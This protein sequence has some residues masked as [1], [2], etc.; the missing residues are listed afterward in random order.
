MSFGHVRREA[1]KV[2]NLMANVGV[3]GGQDLREGKLYEF[4]GEAWVDQC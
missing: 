3:E 4:E 2:V 1:N